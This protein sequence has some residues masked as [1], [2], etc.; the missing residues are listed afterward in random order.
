MVSP[1]DP[2]VG[3]PQVPSLG[4]GSAGEGGGSGGGCLPWEEE[5][6]EDE[7]GG[8]DGLPA[9]QV[10]RVEVLCNGRRHTVA[11]R[12]SE[13]QAL[14]KRVRPPGTTGRGG[15]HAEGTPAPQRRWGPASSSMVH[16]VPPCSTL[17]QEDLQ[18]PRL[19][20]APCPQLD[21]Q[22]AG[23]APAGPG[24]LHTGK[25]PAGSAFGGGF[26]GVLT[27]PPRCTAGCPVPQRGAAPGRAGL[28]EG[29]ALPAG[30]QGHQPP[31]S[32]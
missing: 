11:K 31:V 32:R 2:G 7:D 21:A 20:P 16:G 12:Y 22:S 28:P 3:G 6:D 14:H 5:E 1:S 4:V 8:R 27:P 19:P 23:A 26:F 17:D 25:V 13:F 24:A 30:P 18:G 10:F 9:A 29:A 15:G